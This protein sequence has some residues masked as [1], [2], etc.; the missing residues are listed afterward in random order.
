MNIHHFIN[1][2]NTHYQKT[3]TH[4][5]Y[6]LH[7]ESIFIKLIYEPTEIV[8]IQIPII[9]TQY[10]C[11][12]FGPPHIYTTHNDT[13]DETA[14]KQIFDAIQTF[15]VTIPETD[16][17]EDLFSKNS[18]HHFYNMNRKLLKQYSNNLFGFNIYQMHPKKDETDND[19]LLA[20]TSYQAALKNMPFHLEL[21]IYFHKIKH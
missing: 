6:E 12:R 19:M 8:K 13:P 10:A 2:W 3:H 16:N 11:F 20:K 14:W 15:S 7:D 4:M 1:L 9:R 21:E 5:E 18:I 17:M